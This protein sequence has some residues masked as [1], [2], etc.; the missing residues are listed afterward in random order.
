MFVNK[1]HIVYFPI[2][3]F[4]EMLQSFL[5]TLQLF[6]KTLQGFIENITAFFFFVER[7]A[8]LFVISRLFLFAKSL[9]FSRVEIIRMKM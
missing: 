6:Q 1:I 5:K 4:V 3:V 2:I 7:V 9:D 8:N